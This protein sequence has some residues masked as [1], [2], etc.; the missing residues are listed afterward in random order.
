MA[1]GGDNV[2]KSKDIEYWL[3]KF[4]IFQKILTFT[5][6]RKNPKI[7]L[8]T[9][10][11]LILLMYFFGAKSFLAI[12]RMCRKKRFK[13]LFRCDRKM[14]ASDS[15]IIRALKWIKPEEVQDLN[16]SLHSH[17]KQEHLHRVQLKEGGAFKEIGIVDGTCMN[18]QW[19]SAFVLLG[20]IEN[21]LFIE[22]YNKKG[23][24]L[25]ASKSLL[26]KA[27]KFLKDQF[28]ELVLFDALYFNRNIFKQIRKKNAHIMVKARNPKFREIFK[29][30]QLIFKSPDVFGDT[31]QRD[32][33]FDYERMC[34]W[35]MEVTIA[36]YEGEAV[37]VA[38]LV[39]DYP[40]RQQ[41]KHV[42]SW[43]ITTDMEL[44][45]EEIR[46]AAHLRWHIENN[47][48]KRLSHNA[49][50]KRYHQKESKPFTIFAS[51]L[52][53]ALTLF[54]ML[55]KIL[56]RDEQKFKQLLNGI[57]LTEKNIYSQIEEILKDGIFDLA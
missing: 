47:V 7:K 25:V 4:N 30:A 49:G 42:E 51:L 32:S 33:G 44:D 53:T 41:D 16:I 48:F 56:M 19:L 21:P 8:A 24:E 31:I 22:R 43:I 18:N 50:T 39:E 17:F 35:S 13:R 40:K 37:Q 54:S 52:I 27:S 57:K 20:K 1:L 14:V 28:P 6:K 2:Y 11:L 36:E 45:P 26:N 29:E 55:V 9:I 15:T 34:S 38:H 10:I 23:K 3:K 5:D 12:D 46:E